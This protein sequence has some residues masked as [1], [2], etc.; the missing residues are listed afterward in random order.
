MKGETMTTR[1][2]RTTLRKPAVL[3]ALG[4]KATQFDELVKRGVLPAGHKLSKGGKAIGWWED[5]IIDVQEERAKEPKQQPAP[6]KTA[7]T[8]PKQR[9]L[10]SAKGGA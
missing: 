8:T 6:V 1:K 3:R 2:L 9:L 7:K 5:E 10:A 4:Y